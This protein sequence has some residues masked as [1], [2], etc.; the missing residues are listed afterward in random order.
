[1]RHILITILVTILL[2]SAPATGQVATWQGIVTENWF[3]DLNWNPEAI[4]GAGTNVLIDTT[5]PNPT[6]L[7]GA[8][9]PDLGAIQ[10]GESGTGDLLVELGG[11]LN[12]D[13]IG[14]LGTE[15]GS[16]GFVTVRDAG[17]EWRI[18]HN[19]VVGEQGGGSLQLREE[20][21]VLNDHARIGN[22]AS[23][24]G[25]VSVWSGS[26]WVSLGN[27]FVAHSGTGSLDIRGSSA[28]YN[29]AQAF[30][31]Y[32]GSGEGSVRV[33]EGGGWASFDDVFVGRQGQGKLDIESGGVVLAT[34]N[35]NSFV[36][37]QSGGA[38][39]V[40][41]TGPGSRWTTEAG[42]IIGVGGNGQL[43][44][45]NGGEV[46]G[47]IVSIGDLASGTGTVTVGENSQLISN[48]NLIV[49][50]VGTGTLT[51]DG[52]EVTND[53]VGII[54]NAADG[55]GEVILSSAGSYWFSQND[56]LVGN[57][58]S[59][60]LTVSSAAEVESGARVLISANPGGSG[61]VEL[62]GTLT[63]S[64][65]HGGTQV[66][67]GG[68]LTGFGTIHG[69]LHVNAGGIVAPGVGEGSIGTLTVNG[70]LNLSSAESVLEFDL[71]NFSVPPDPPEP[72]SDRIDVNG[73]LILNGTLN[74]TVTGV[75]LPGIYTLISYTGTMTDQGLAIGSLPPP[76]GH[77]A[78]I[79]T[80]TQPG[81]VRLVVDELPDEMFSD[82]FEM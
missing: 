12:N 19:L 32:A 5:M 35:S 31:G 72:V 49:G 16:V 62:W 73:D 7:A 48:G 69:G 54:G 11:K 14:V 63:A 64:T 82:R 77:G 25:T 24:S 20:G 45:S 81:E 17:S 1:M 75:F 70:N 34:N 56:I 3:N 28:V 80:T 47:N 6:T 40:T 46:S 51:V 57:N 66:R 78:W 68:R 21:Y 60:S 55:N 9:T 53:H 18:D 23:G 37:T 42:L 44:V 43:D 39:E 15:S 8:A 41:V 10:V 27:L 33:R 30:V 50:A 76:T 29:Q 67:D 59:G 4:P 71:S 22:S 26:N 65:D 38:G 58:G 61:L 2:A 36:G 79:D 74:A 13:G 52:G